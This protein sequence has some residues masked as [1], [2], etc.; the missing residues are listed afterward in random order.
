MVSCLAFHVLSMKW[1]VSASRKLM[2]L[3]RV[4]SPDEKGR[5]EHLLSKGFDDKARFA[6]KDVYATDSE[7]ET[8]STEAFSSTLGIFR[9]PRIKICSTIEA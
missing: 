9:N 8:V 7:I 6:R 2:G 4:L 5:L 3:P 1:A